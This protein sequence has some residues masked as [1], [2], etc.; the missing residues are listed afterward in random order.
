MYSALIYLL[1][2]VRFNQSLFSLICVTIST[3]T[4]THLNSWVKRSNAQQSVLLKGT[5]ATVATR[6]QTHNL[7]TRPSEHKS[8]ALSR[9]AMAP[10]IASGRLNFA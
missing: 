6:I 4:G 7:T 9:L 5:S 2:Y 3:L 10:H 8:D 1:G